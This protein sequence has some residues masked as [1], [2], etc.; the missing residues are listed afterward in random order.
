MEKDLLQS[1]HHIYF[2]GIGGS[3]MSPLAD[4]LHSLGYRISGSDINESDNL[5]RMRSLGIPVAMQQVAENITDD[6][7]LFVYTTAVGEHNPEL[8][9]AQARSIP[10]LERAKLL[11]LITRRYPRTIAVAGTHGKTTTSSMLSQ[12]LLDGGFD[13]AV[14]IGGRLPLIGAN[15]RAGKSDIMVCEACEFKD[16]YLSMAPAI[17][18]I[19]NIDADHLDYFGS[20]DGVIRSFH[21][22]AE[23][24]ASILIVNRDDPNAAKALEGI[25]GKKVVF[26]STRSDAEWTA[27]NITYDHGAYGRYDLYHNGEFFACISLGVPGEHNVGNSMA[28][29]AAAH[30]CG[31]SADQIADGIAAFH[32]AGRRFEFLGEFGGVTIVDDYAHHPTEI[33]ATI[34]AAKKLGYRQVWAVFQPFTYSRTAQHLE[35]FA[36]VL[37]EADHAI[38]SDIMGSREQNT[39]GV[40]SRQITDRIPGSH[41]LPTFEDITEYMV[42]HVQSGDLILT[43]GGGDIYK[44]ARMMAKRLAGRDKPKDSV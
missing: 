13:P 3:G 11:G 4:I 25:S 34:T 12:I 17:S 29:A 35:E 20:L 36:D 5:A 24:T 30:L 23:L 6:I 37:K 26:Y 31:A 2:S 32:G 28:A 15:G 8:L 1:V 44:C 38:V 16:H 10:T 19:L 22:F 14:F 21:A 42:Q 27:R 43:M 7:D 41:Y 18:I 9:A 39:W 40:S 33:H